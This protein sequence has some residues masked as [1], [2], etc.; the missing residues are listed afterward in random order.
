LPSL[1]KKRG[2]GTQRERPKGL[3]S[4]SP[5]SGLGNLG[6]IVFGRNGHLYICDGQGDNIKEYEPDDWN[7]VN[8]SATVQE[9]YD[10]TF[11][12]DGHLYVSS[13][14]DDI[15]V[16]FDGGDIGTVLEQSFT[17]NVLDDP[18]GIRFGRRDRWL[19]EADNHLLSASLG[20]QIAFT[21]TAGMDN[22]NRSYFLAG[23]MS[24]SHPGTFLP[25]GAATIPLMRDW[26]SNYILS[27][28]T[29]PSFVNF[30][31]RLDASGNGEAQLIA[32]GPLPPSMLGEVM[33][34]AYAVYNPWDFASNPVRIEIVQ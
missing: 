22:A 14:Q 20:G 8:P 15:I 10:L 34:F 33:H 2:L 1:G 13:Y 18:V 28:L 6:N 23:T 16:K 11:G 7:L 17:S 21:L 25:G 4:L 19:L 27:H 9:P 29:S 12:P 5:S 31:A 3:R 24:G 26:L 30:S 32:S